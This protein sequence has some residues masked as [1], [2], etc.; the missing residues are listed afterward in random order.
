MI[1]VLRLPFA[2]P[3]S[4]SL[5]EAFL[6]G[7]LCQFKYVCGC[8]YAKSHTNELVNQKKNKQFGTKRFQRLRKIHPNSCY[9]SEKPQGKNF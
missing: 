4:N 7:C 2:N 5:V 1:C 8:E 9:R 6:S 3:Q